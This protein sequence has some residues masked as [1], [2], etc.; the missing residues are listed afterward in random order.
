MFKNALLSMVL[1]CVSSLALALPNPCAPK[2]AK[3]DKTF[4]C[5][6]ALAEGDEVQYFVTISTLESPSN[7]YCRGSKVE[8]A[9][10]E[11]L[12]DHGEPSGK[13]TIY[14]GYFEYSYPTRDKPYISFKSE[15]YNLDLECEA[16][17]GGGFSIG[18]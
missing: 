7:R 16:P 15:L 11:L 8:T 10:I 1:V 3:E 14:D 5:N 2:Q 13:I 18:N 17:I 12:A 6:V 4:T 9:N